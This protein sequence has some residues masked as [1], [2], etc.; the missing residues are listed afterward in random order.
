VVELHQ[1]PIEGRE[2]LVPES[3]FQHQLADHPRQ[4]A[5]EQARA[6]DLTGALAEVAPAKS[7]DPRLQRRRYLEA[8]Q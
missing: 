1:R 2:P 8:T 6:A 7:G 4:S 3:T 5:V